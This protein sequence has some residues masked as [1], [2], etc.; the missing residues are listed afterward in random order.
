MPSPAYHASWLRRGRRC[1]CQAA[2]TTKRGRFRVR[3]AQ[4]VR[5]ACNTCVFHTKR[6]PCC[7]LPP[8]PPALIRTYG[9]AP[10][11]GFETQTTKGMRNIVR[12]KRCASMS[13]PGQCIGRR[14]LISV[15]CGQRFA[16]KG[17]LT[18]RLAGMHDNNGKPYPCDVCDEV[19]RGKDNFNAHVAS[20][21]MKEEPFQ[22]EV[23]GT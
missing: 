15:R 14:D 2:K 21:H 7:R 17:G 13:K 4:R 8:P 1:P 16:R 18:A 19:F 11:A 23:C 20:V 6:L 5:V 22:C 12:K 9:A 10:A 3:R